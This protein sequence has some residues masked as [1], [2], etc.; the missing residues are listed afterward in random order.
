MADTGQTLPADAPAPAATSLSADFDCIAA[1]CGAGFAGIA[2]LLLDAGAD[3]GASTA[4][5]WLPLHEAA[6]NGH[7]E[8]V[9]RL[10]E[11][12]SQVRPPDCSIV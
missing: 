2:G 10:L 5:G 12:K 9:Q 4:D 11:A 6:F 8:I 7:L 1:P 3:V